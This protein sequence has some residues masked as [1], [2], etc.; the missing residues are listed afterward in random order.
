MVD[1]LE[2][3]NI[4]FYLERRSIAYEILCQHVIIKLDIQSGKIQIILILPVLYQ[5]IKNVFF[6]KLLLRKYY[7]Y[8]IVQLQ[9]L[10]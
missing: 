9:Y 6:T 4:F 2:H 10:Y 5:F 7:S 3:K 1:F 8:L